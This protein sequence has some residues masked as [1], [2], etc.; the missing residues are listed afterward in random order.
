MSRRFGL[1]RGQAIDRYYIDDF[2]RRHAVGPA[3]YERDGIRGR[4]LE[5]GEP[6][7]ARGF[8]DP[9]AID[10][11]DVLDISPLNSQATIVADLAEGRSVPSAAFDCVLCTQTLL[12]I[13]DV[14]AAVRTLHRILKPGG[15]LLATM[16]GISQICHPE[17]ETLG[18]CWRFTTFSARRLFEE[19]FD[20]SDITVEA[21]GN[22]LAAAAFLY[23]LTVEDLTRE[24]LDAHDPD[25]QVT[26]AV[27]A[28]KR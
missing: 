4:V 5:I 17:M 3:G 22:V 1:D 16:P 21:Y 10:Q 12:L 6:R 20:P 15:M 27:K 23:G 19:V 28:V 11:I 9:A 26:I 14:P 24:E 18:D 7:Y 8:G 13:Y 2:L 25:Y